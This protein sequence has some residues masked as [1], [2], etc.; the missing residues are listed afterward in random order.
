[1]YFIFSKIL[2][3]LLY[4]ALW[5]FVLFVIS[6]FAGNSKRKQRLLLATLILFYVFS[7]PL[8]INLLARG[9]SVRPSVTNPNTIYSS[10]IV[11]GGFTSFDKHNHGYFNGACDRFIE[12]VRVLNTGCVKHILVSGGNGTLRQG[13]FKEATWVK[14]QLKLFK[15]PDSCILIEANS[16]N[17]IENAV[18]S[19]AVL[20]KAGLKPP[21]LL[22]TSDFHMRRAMMI[23]QKKGLQVVPYPCDFTAGKVSGVSFSDLISDGSSFGLWSLYLKELVGYGV[24]YWK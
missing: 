8:F 5:V 15:V 6:L 10:A 17:T 21:Y 4:P 20:Q 3:F 12:A 1:M 9:W 7:I 13:T 24:D 2:L 19:R 14:T 11:L 23:F 22:I 16:R 18:F